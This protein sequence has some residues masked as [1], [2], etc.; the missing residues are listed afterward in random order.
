VNLNPGDDQRALDELRKADIC[1]WVLYQA[2]CKIWTE[3]ERRNF[4]A[5]MHYFYKYT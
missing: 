5:E 4:N 3:C 2:Y 1:L